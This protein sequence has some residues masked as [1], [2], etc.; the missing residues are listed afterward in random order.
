M[1][2]ETFQYKK[3]EVQLTFGFEENEK[4]E[5]NKRDF[6]DLLKQAVADLEMEVGRTGNRQ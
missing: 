4:K 5:Q 3:G 6:L 1:K 2:L